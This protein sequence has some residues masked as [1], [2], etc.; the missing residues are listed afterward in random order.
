MMRRPASAPY[1]AVLGAAA[2]LLLGSGCASR[3]DWIEATLVT[4][5]VTGRWRGTASAGG[6]AAGAA[7]VELALDQEGPRVKGF[8]RV[9]P[10]H[11]SYG[12]AEG[13]VAGEIT[14]DVFR[15]QQTNGPVWGEATVTI[16]QML[17][18][19]VWMSVYKLTLRRAERS[20]PTRP[21]TQ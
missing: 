21:Q 8:L 19:L 12:S 9:R 11:S 13:P 14:G 7:S 16:D 6:G 1:L 20:E 2:G 5:D 10:I 18:Q 15:F 3:P 4:V 17:G